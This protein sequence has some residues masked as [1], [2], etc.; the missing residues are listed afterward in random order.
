MKEV[1]PILLSRLKGIDWALIGTFNLY[2][3]G[4]S[5]DPNDVDIL[6]TAKDI[7]KIAR[8]FGSSVFNEHGYDETETALDGIAV[9]AVTIDGNPL[10][11]HQSLTN[12]KIYLD[13]DNLKVPCMSPESELKFYRQAGREKDKLK[14]KLIEE[15]LS[16]ERT[17]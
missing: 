5:V 11:G 16:Q 1:L 6:T 14:V 13:I 7:K 12:D 4:I 15:A 10:R 3:Q 17:R 2:L 8:V 9:H